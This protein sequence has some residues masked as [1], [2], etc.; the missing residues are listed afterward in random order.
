MR[1]A[2]FILG[3]IE[4]IMH[5]WED[6]ARSLPPGS[7]MNVA[8]L[9][10]DAEQML[11]FV[12]QDM[13]TQ[14]SSREQY[15]KSIGGGKQPDHDSSAAR[16]HGL[17]RAKDRFSL[18]ELVS[19]Y[20]ALRASVLSLWLTS[21]DA[22]SDMQ[23]VIRFNEAIDQL[24]AE[25]VQRYSGKLDRDADV[26]TASIGHDL[27]NPLNAISMSAQLLDNSRVLSQPEKNAVH[28]I[29]QS[30]ARMANMI[31][32]LQDFSRVRLSTTL[33]I[34]RQLLNVAD[35]CEEV[36]EEI[37]AA[38]PQCKIAFLKS[39]NTM[40]TVNGERI[41]QM[42]SNLVSNAVQHGTPNCDVEVAVQA[43][44]EAVTIA[45]TNEGPQIPAE[46]LERIFE[47]LFR[48]DD[49]PHA[50]RTHLGLG[51]YIARTI[52]RAH[53]GDINVTSTESG[54]TF[55][56]RIPRWASTNAGTQ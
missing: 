22:D 38:I 5:A 40:A 30:A 15:L 23:Q 14:Q 49:S 37:R 56:V 24:I 45:V 36:V 17:A 25:S 31:N 18:S 29:S 46:A 6:F 2:N 44:A 21:P 26:F 43:D 32:E 54:T 7:R 42:L 52:A 55:E 13:E 34:N 20:R 51:L 39:G 9:R 47:P 41:G 1:L 48:T 33:T 3:N 53:G 8:A 35:V 4:S 16:D 19:E 28:Q 27:R 10:N 50:N 11:R 12:A